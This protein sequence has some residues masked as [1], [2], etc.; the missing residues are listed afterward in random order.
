MARPRDYRPGLYARFIR[1]PSAVGYRRP[2]IAPKRVDYH[3]F[4]SN[5]PAIDE[6][7]QLVADKKTAV[8]SLVSRRPD[9]TEQ[10]RLPISPPTAPGGR[11]S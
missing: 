8:F 3:V 6:L 5:T 4:I 1:S 10:S 2:S 9:S 7:D 11:F